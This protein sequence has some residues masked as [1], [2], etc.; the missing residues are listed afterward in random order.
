MTALS[1]LRRVVLVT[2]TSVV[3]RH[4]SPATAYRKTTVGRAIWA[5]GIMIRAGGIMIMVILNIRF[6][7]HHV[8][9]MLMA[10]PPPERAGQGRFLW[11]NQVPPA[12]PSLGDHL[13]HGHL[14]HANANEVN[15]IA[16]RDV[17]A[18]VPFRSPYLISLHEISLA[19]ILACQ[20]SPV[21]SQSV[22]PRP[23]SMPSSTASPRG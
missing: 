17:A 8:I 7:M 15:L 11:E 19:R 2:F 14:T 9:L 20:P 12:L 4:A 18:A 22:S 1:C 6:H 10:S 13:T 21:C 23:D 5:G 16:A 3:Q